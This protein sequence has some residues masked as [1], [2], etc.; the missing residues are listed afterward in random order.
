MHTIEI[1]EADVKLTLPES[2]EEMT[3]EQFIFTV[4]MFLALVAGRINT[5][6][7]YNAVLARFIGIET[8]PKVLYR[9]IAKKYG[10]EVVENY[11]A[12][13]ISLHP[14]LEFILKKDDE[15]SEITFNY[16]GV[17]NKIPQYHHLIGPQDAMMDCTFGEWIFLNDMLRDYQETPNIQILN[18]IVGTM[19]R[20]EI[21]DY[22]VE[23]TQPSFDGNRRMPF[24]KNLTEIYTLRVE[25]WDYTVKYAILLFL[26]NCI[27]FM[28]NGEIMLHGNKISFA[29]LFTKSKEGSKSSLGSTGLA[30]KIAETGIFGNIKD[31]LNEN[32]Y[33]VYLKM[34]QW[35]EEYEDFTNKT[36][37]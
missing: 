16:S 13:I 37:K 31:T 4:K 11:Y 24:N 14:L 21:P 34:L 30:Y 35:N 36:K 29:K 15:S 25:K 1:P 3:T 26:K 8:E 12:N 2:F 23:K 27:N 22:E 9:S 33:N 20:D 7:F 5:V 28:H 6:E 17:N 19:Y 10:E 18:T 32:V